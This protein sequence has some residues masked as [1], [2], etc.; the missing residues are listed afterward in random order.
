MR[1]HVS[2]CTLA[3]AHTQLAHCPHS[4]ILQ[5]R[6]HAELKDLDGVNSILMELLSPKMLAE[7]AHSNVVLTTQNYE[8]LLQLM[9][10]LLPEANAK[11]CALVL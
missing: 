2:F 4:H 6:I 7:M 9:E 10:D 3:H 11:V 8:V 1:E 5:I